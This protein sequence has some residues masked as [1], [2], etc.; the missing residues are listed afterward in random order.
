[1]MILNSVLLK[2][3]KTTESKTGRG[4]HE[5]KKDKERAN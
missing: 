5:K 3:P 2:K 4:S 1:M